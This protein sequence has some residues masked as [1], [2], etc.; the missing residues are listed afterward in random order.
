MDEGNVLQGVLNGLTCAGWYI[1]VAVG[2]SLVLSIMN[3]VQLSHGEIYMIGAYVV[4]YFCVN[5]GIS[6]YL[7][8]VIAVLASGILGIVLSASSSGPS[9]VSPTRP[10][11]CPSG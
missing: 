6:F 1:L 8:F 3:I 7:A 5:A 10:W 11:C 9:G 2:L 4:Y